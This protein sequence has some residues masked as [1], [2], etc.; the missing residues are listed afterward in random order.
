MRCDDLSLNLIGSLLSHLFLLD[1]SL[2]LEIISVSSDLGNDIICGSFDL[3][4]ETL[5]LSNLDI[6]MRLHFWWFCNFLN[7]SSAHF[8][9]LFIL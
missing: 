5:G 7:F 9:N 1:S 4:E 2:V 6:T 8:Q 3:V